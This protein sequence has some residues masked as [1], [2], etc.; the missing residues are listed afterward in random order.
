MRPAS[1]KRLSLV[2]LAGCI[3][4]VASISGQ[5]KQQPRPLQR[6]TATAQKKTATGTVQQK[7]AQA[8]APFTAL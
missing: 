3:F 4:F 1:I 7:Q 2:A 6:T 5:Q 8:A